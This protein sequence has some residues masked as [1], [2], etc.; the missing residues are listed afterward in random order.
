MQVSRPEYFRHPS[1]S[2]HLRWGGMREF[3]RAGFVV[4]EGTGQHSHRNVQPE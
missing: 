2:G 3:A 1:G 4:Q